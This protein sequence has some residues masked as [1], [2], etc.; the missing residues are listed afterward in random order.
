MPVRL[1]QEPAVSQATLLVI[2]GVDQGTRFEIDADEVGLGRG[3]HNA[4]RIHDTEVSR[5][6]AKLVRANGRYQLNDLHSSNGTFI[7]GT[8][9]NSR[10]LAAGDEVQIGRTVLLFTM[11]PARNERAV[12]TDK[13]ALVAEPGP[14]PSANIVG[15]TSPHDGPALATLVSDAGR[16]QTVANLQVLYRIAEEAVRPS[17]SIDQLL[18]RILELTIE[19]TGADRGCVLLRDSQTGEV[20]PQ[21]FRHRPGLKETD[22]M[23]VSRSI[24]DYVLKTRQGVRT[25]DARSDARFIPGQSILQGGIREAICVPMQGRYDLQGAVYIDITTPP[26]RALLENK[27]QGRFHE[28]LL[29]LMVAIARQSALAVEDN[30]YQLALVKAERL[31]AVGQTIA[32]LSHHI[33]NILQGV[34]GGS[35]LIDMG[36]KDHNEDLVRKGWGIVDKNQDKIYQLVMDMLTFSKERQPVLKPADLNET[37]GDVCELLMARAA[38]L[39]VQLAWAPASNLPPM[40]IDAEGIHRAVLN[41]VGNALD[42]AEGREGAAVHVATNYVSETSLVSVTVTDNGPGIPSELLPQIFNIFESTK[43]ARGTGIGLAVSQKIIREHGGD[44]LVESRTGEGAKF[45]LEWPLIEEA[46]ES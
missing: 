27:P 25:S 24:V 43:G 37:A 6:H 15:Q 32:I 30:R 29:R 11:Q 13:V 20:S 19:V 23:G 46:A 8:Q 38:E 10:D 28:E 9:I 44:I 7:N 33:K 26:E 12:V 42:A 21:V 31:A 5:A 3:V 22:R 40:C 4:V 16:A 45:T 2:Q 17:N 36:L 1:H 34:R 35:Y 18:G 41:I 39:K 14:D